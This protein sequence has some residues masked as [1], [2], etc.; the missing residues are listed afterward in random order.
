MYK[1]F[2]LGIAALLI[3][4]AALAAIVTI[5]FN[6]TIDRKTTGYSAPEQGFEPL[7]NQKAQLTFDNTL[8]RNENY[9][10]TNLY[11]INSHAYAWYGDANFA[12]V[13]SPVSALMDQNPL[14][15]AP[16]TRQSSMRSSVGY[17]FAPGTNEV[18]Y[19]HNVG[20]TVALRSSVCASKP[21]GYEGASWEH[22]VSL[23]SPTEYLGN[24]S[25]A[26]IESYAFSTSDLMAQLYAMQKAGAAFSFGDSTYYEER[27]SLRYSR[28]GLGGSA[29]I[30]KIT[31]DGVSEVPEPGSFAL[32]GLGALGLVAARRKSNNLS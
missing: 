4:D 14:P 17:S 2:I 18:S 9:W 24:L 32:L 27:P 7:V 12:D 6:V 25:K 23:Y 15:G 28:M 31:V 19:F 16:V 22:T 26:D 29:V 30:S 1:A 21:C 8:K 3:S 20:A 11:P 5:D 13:T 10:D